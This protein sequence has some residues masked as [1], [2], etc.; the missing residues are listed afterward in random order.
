MVDYYAMKIR[1]TQIGLY[2]NL[3]YIFPKKNELFPSVIYYIYISRG[4]R[5]IQ[6]FLELSNYTFFCKCRSFIQKFCTCFTNVKMQIYYAR[7]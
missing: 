6:T 3:N 2:K 4:K 5:V 7:T 1:F